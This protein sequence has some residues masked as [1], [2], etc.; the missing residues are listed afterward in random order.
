MIYEKQKLG[1]PVSKEVDSNVFKAELVLRVTHAQTKED[2]EQ[3]REVAIRE[4]PA[5]MKDEFLQ[6]LLAKE[7]YKDAKLVTAEKL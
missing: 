3:G 6:E 4:Y 7:I 5:T 1:I 2:L